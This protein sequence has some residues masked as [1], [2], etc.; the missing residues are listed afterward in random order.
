MTSCTQYAFGLAHPGLDA[1]E[2]GGGDV[3]GRVDPETVDA[4][5][6]QVAQV[7]GDGLLDVRAAGVEVGEVDQL[8]VL[9]VAAVAVVGDG[10]AA[11]VEVLVLVVPG[12]V[13]L[14][15]DGAAGA[16]A[17]AGRHVVDHRV[18]DHL[19]AGGV[20]GAHHGLERGPVA[21][22]AGD[23]VAD[24]LVGGPPLGSLDVLL[25]R[26][27]LDEAVALGAERVGAGLRHRVELHSNRVAVTSLPPP[28]GLAAAVGASE[29]PAPTDSARAAAAVSA[30]AARAGREVGEL[31][32]TV[33]PG[34]GWAAWFGPRTQVRGPGC[35]E[36]QG[37]AGGMRQD[38][39]AADGGAQSTGPERGGWW[40]GCPRYG[41]V[42]C[43]KLIETFRKL[44]VR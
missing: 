38:R 23:P 42:T 7:V 1:R 20:A 11:G 8:A 30:P 35:E 32:T 43:C 4:D 3:L 14:A 26:R 12:V 9:H 21:E 36:V 13:V 29:S 24:G 22:P 40:A 34:G 19:D 39:R 37:G 6:E 31:V 28:G 18:G 25:G 27:D 15:V 44:A 10:A 5:R 33:S 41:R 2:V 17:G 16:G